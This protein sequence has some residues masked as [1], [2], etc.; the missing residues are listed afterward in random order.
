MSILEEMVSTEK[1]YTAD[2]FHA[3]KNA[4]LRGEYL[5][6]IRLYV[7][8]PGFQSE[9]TGLLRMR[10]LL[11]FI[12]ARAVV[13]DAIIRT[14]GTLHYLS[15]LCSSMAAP[16]SFS[17]IMKK[18]VPQAIIEETGEKIA[19]EWVASRS[20]RSGVW[21]AIPFGGA[22]K[23]VNESRR[24]LV[25]LLL[26]YRALLSEC[27]AI[28]PSR[29]N[30]ERAHAASGLAVQFLL[31][32]QDGSLCGLPDFQIAG[33][34]KGANKSHI[35]QL[36]HDCG[37]RLIVCDDLVC[38]KELGITDLLFDARKRRGFYG[39]SA[40]ATGGRFSFTLVVPSFI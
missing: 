21:N 27:N 17:R 35:I 20:V 7:E 6:R 24:I 26:E 25:S 14:E 5:Y 2:N 11:G 36:Q 19:E 13:I 28:V 23:V 16:E 10:M 18:T 32:E 8:R 29:G 15:V 31:F 1:R 3:L 40:P 33:V 9:E 34:S 37:Q 4:S 22:V 39:V 38:M 12:E 30:T